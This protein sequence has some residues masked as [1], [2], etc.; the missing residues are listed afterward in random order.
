[1]SAIVGIGT[2]D[3]EKHRFIDIDNR[4]SLLTALE[5]KK[6]QKLLELKIAVHNSCE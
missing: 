4:L 5:R 3:T 2:A 1:M 6:N